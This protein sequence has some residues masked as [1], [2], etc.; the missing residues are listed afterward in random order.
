MILYL[1][2]VPGF[3]IAVEE[4]RRPDLRSRPVIM[5]GLPHQRGTVREANL[6]AQRR[7]VY[8]GMTLSQAHQQCPDGLFLLPDIP[9]YEGVWEGICELLSAHT[10]LVEPVEMG[11]AVCDLSGCE[12]RWRDAWSMARAVSQEIR[13]WT[14]IAPWIGVGPNR[15]VA[16]LA[17]TTVGAD[18]ITVVEVGQERRF[19]TNLPITL[20]PDV[21]PHLALTF[22]VLGLRTIG[23][24]AALP[25]A[26]VKQR[27]GAVGER[28]HRYARGID[29]RP[30]VPPAPRASVSARYD[31]ED[32]TLE[33]ASAAIHR[34]AHTCAAE[35]Q[36]RHL[37]GRLVELTLAWE[38]SPP[39]QLNGAQLPL[40]GPSSDR[41]N[42]SVT[43]AGG[44]PSPSAS[45][46]DMPQCTGS[47]KGGEGNLLPITSRIH[48]M[49]PQPG[50]PAPRPALPSPAGAGS[51]SDSILP[52][53][54]RKSGGR[55][56]L[57]KLVATVRTPI[58]TPAPLAE[59]AHQLLR[60]KWPQ[61]SDEDLSSPK[62]LTIELKVSEFAAPVQRSFEEF[63]Q[64]GQTGRLSGLTSNRLL[65]LAE[66]EEVLAARYGDASFRHVAH[67]DPGS[68]LTERR[69]R[70]GRGLPWQTLS[71][72]RSGARRRRT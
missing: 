26:A 10:P 14:G 31:C 7:G 50:H 17:S 47:S 70:W 23:Q 56:G 15:L 58:E 21:D 29:R 67:V 48:S 37:A 65:A 39:L 28:L 61:T 30:V 64:L 72:G 46:T 53:G 8:S 52:L 34:L 45:R 55:D 5:G 54:T 33:E 43:V 6:P 22:Q 62:L 38:T 41:R 71:E 59:R 66:Q 18:G 25:A 44:G 57:T 36:S 2:V 51:A 35:L 1:R 63:L 68:I 32:G 20:L 40:G 19:L 49:L 60:Q 27:F 12:R 11:Q 4:Q 69:F 24:L 16:E 9:H 42:G 13:R 3:W